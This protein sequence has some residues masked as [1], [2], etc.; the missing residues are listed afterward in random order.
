MG[1]MLPLFFRWEVGREN[2][3]VLAN[4]VSLTRDV[5]D[6]PNGASLVDSQLRV[7]HSEGQGFGRG[8]RRRWVRLIVAQPQPSPPSTGRAARSASRRPYQAAHPPIL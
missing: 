8:S 7:S 5:R 4:I 6:G 3:A 1:T 2:R